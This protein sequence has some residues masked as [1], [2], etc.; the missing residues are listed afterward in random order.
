MIKKPNTIEQE[1]NKAR[2]EIYFEQKNLSADERAKQMQ[3]RTQ[4]YAE[5]YGM[6]IAN[7]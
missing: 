3:A 4:M 5:K 7:N 2:V 1:I 6:R